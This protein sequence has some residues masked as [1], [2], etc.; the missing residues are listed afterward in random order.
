M[1]KLNINEWIA[2]VIAGVIVVYFFFFSGSDT[3]SVQNV[4]SINNVTTETATTSMDTT[5]N[6]LIITDTELGTGAEAVTGKT[7]S[8]NYTGKLTNGT[9]FDSSIPRG[10]PIEF[11][12]GSR[13]VIQGWEEGILGM[14]VGGKRTLTISPEKAY[15]SQGVPGVIP[16]NATL[17]FDVELM[18]VK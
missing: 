10:E 13:R 17:I 4:E 12:L 9:V 11:V 2:V 7:V 1:K 18:D 8:V 16:P 5:N 14:K 6:G 15:G 3:F